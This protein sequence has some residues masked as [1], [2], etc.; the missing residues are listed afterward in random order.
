VGESSGITFNLLGGLGSFILPLFALNIA[1]TTG[2]FVVGVRL[3]G[4]DALSPLTLGGIAGVVIGY[5]SMVPLVNGLSPVAGFPLPVAL[6]G[7]FPRDAR[8]NMILLW[9]DSLFVAALIA[10]ARALILRRRNRS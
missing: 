7:E 1:L 3:F 6:A 2:A 5:L 9:L 8:P 10:C 4:R